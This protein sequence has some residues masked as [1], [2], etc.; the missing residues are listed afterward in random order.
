[1]SRKLYLFI[2]VIVS[3]GV[4][5]F[6]FSQAIFSPSGIM[7]SAEGD[8]AKNYY[9]VMYHV[10][11]GDGIWFDGMNYPYG[12]HMVFTDAQPV[13]SIFLATVNNYFSLNPLAVMNLCMATG[14]F[15]G[16]IYVWKI[17]LRF[18]V[19]PLW[20][21][22]AAVLIVAMSP[23]QF[24]LGGHFSLAY[25]FVLP[26]VFY[27]NLLW[28]QTRK[29]VYLWALFS[30]TI[31]FTFIHLYF[32]LMICLWLALYALGYFLFYKT[33]LKA[34]VKHVVPLLLSG[35]VPVLLFQV[36]MILTD[37]VSDRPSYPYGARAHGT[38]LQDIFTSFLSPF[39]LWISRHYDIGTLSGGNEGYAYIGLAP[40]L[41]L[42]AGL[43]WWITTIIRS[44][45]IRLRTSD[46][47]SLGTWIFV[48]AG[49]LVF[50]SA[51][52]FI[53]CFTC[54][55]HASFIKQFRAI[56]RFSWGYY[57]IAA[58]AAVVM[59][60]RWLNILLQRQKKIIAWTL[61]LVLLGVWVAEAIPFINM[62]RQRAIDGELQYNRFYKINGEEWTQFLGQRGYTSDSFRALY[63]IPYFH[64]G[65]EKLGLVT[66]SYDLPMT[67][68]S[69]SLLLHLPMMNVMM[70]RNSWSQAFEQVKVSGGPFTQKKVLRSGDNRP[71]LVI[72]PAAVRL[73]KDEEYLLSSAEKLGNLD[74]NDIYSLRTDVLLQKEAEQAKALRPIF[75][76]MTGADTC[77]NYHGQWHV[78]H[79]DTGMFR[80][81]LFGNGAARAI[82]GITKIVFNAPL[83]PM[84]DSQLYEF[85]CW[86]LVSDKDYKIGRFVVRCHDRN[87]SLLTDVTVLAQESVDNYGLWLRA[88]KYLKVPA[89][90][91]K[92]SVELQNIV[93]PSYLA[94]DELMI[95]PADA[96]IL[97]RSVNGQKMINNHVF[98]H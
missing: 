87:D 32:A 88:S 3:L 15:L 78:E 24:K 41:I 62:T 11:Y 54:L 94:L 20:A 98:Y 93:Y 39:S 95:R 60:Y 12:E 97:S 16:I 42:S 77:I 38:S 45:Q 47:N 4:T 90:C 48:A 21:T 31:I 65:T 34:K 63:V 44:R 73:N 61:V 50:G 29:P 96:Q 37:P 76:A 19:H 81:A 80:D 56:G 36:F 14:F 43:L 6:T 58:I 64:I 25:F 52:I 40:I 22:A 57:Y 59:L 82:D 83:V 1:M 53:K 35:I 33:T 28:M 91:V 7:F 71:L 5:I 8:G 55:D 66:A 85:S 10:L 26:V 74:G 9:T 67:A 18:N 86:M 72:H 75:R 17:L 68:F 2:A 51:I 23:Q 89:A 79:F 13:F 30:A 69:T 92:I 84:Y 27:Y 46:S 70:S 49:M